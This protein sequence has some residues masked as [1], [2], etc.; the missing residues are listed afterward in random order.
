MHIK[1]V[2]C[3]KSVLF[4]FNIL[5]ARKTIRR[6]T[7]QGRKNPSF[8]NAKRFFFLFSRVF[9]PFPAPHPC[10][11]PLC[12]TFV[13]SRSP[14]YIYINIYLPISIS[15]IFVP[16]LRSLVFFFGFNYKTFA[17]MVSI[18]KLEINHSNSI[19]RLLLKLAYL[20]PQRL[21]A[22]L[23]SLPVIQLP[24]TYLPTYLPTYL[25]PFLAVHTTI[26]VC[27]CVCVVCVPALFLSSP[28]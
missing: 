9:P 5:V 22:P 23:P 14:R 3:K 15:H 27:V 24:K 6:E 13:L 1:F 19:S 12:L 18:I 16:L 7:T 26:R 20:P 4:F 10:V 21:L 2:R 11:H 25:H 8:T 28:N 17:V